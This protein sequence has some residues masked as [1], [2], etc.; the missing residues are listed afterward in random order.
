MNRYCLTIILI[1]LTGNLFAQDPAGLKDNIGVIRDWSVY[2]TSLVR[3]SDPPA[4]RIELTVNAPNDIAGAILEVSNGK[5]RVARTELPNLKKGSNEIAVFLPEPKE[6][7]SAVWRILDGKKSDQILAQKNLTWNKPR[8]WTIYMIGSTHTDIGLHN[9]QYVQR[10]MTVGYLDKVKDLIDANANRPDPSRYRYMIEGTWVW[11]NYEHD[12]SEKTAQDFAENYIKKGMVALGCTCAGNHTQVYGFEELCRSTYYKQMLHDRWG[13]DSDTMIMSDNNGMIWSIVA[14]YRNAGI[15]NIIFSP[16]QWNPLPSTIFKMD[17]SVNGANWNPDAGGG[18]SRIDVRYDSPLPMVFYWLGADDSSKMLVWCVPLYGNGGWRFGFYGKG[19]MDDFGEMVQKV[20]KQLRKLEDRYPFDIWLFTQYQDDQA[21]NLYLADTAKKWNAQW[22]SPEFRT[23]GDISEPFNRL[24]EKYED[25]IT[26]LRGD[27]TSGWSQHPVAAPELLAQK[28]NADVALANAE[29]LAALA[30][31]LDEKY[32]YPAVELR[33]AWD[34]LI[35]NDEHSYG[36][37]GYKGRRVFETWIQHRDWIDKAE[38]TARSV[39]Q[40]ALDVLGKKISVQ[41]DSILLFNPTLIPRSEIMELSVNGKTVQ[42]RTPKIPSFGYKVVSKKDL[43]TLSAVPVEKGSEKTPPIMENRF[44][45]ILFASDGSIQSIFDKDLGRELIDQKS[46]YRC[47]QFVYTKDNH[48]T[49]LSPEK[50][51]F[52]MKSDSL[53]STVIARLNDKNT[54]AE[55]TQAVFLPNGEKRIDLDNQ[56]KH[57]YDLFNTN[58]YYRY[59]YY[60]FPFDVPQGQFYAQLNGAIARPKKDSTG[61]GTDAYLA[62]RDWTAVENGSFGAALIQIDSNLIEFGQIHAD[63][64]DYD[65]P[66]RTSHLYSYLFNDWLQMHTSGGSK[67]EPRFRYTIYSYQGNYQSADLSRL[68]Q[69]TVNPILWKDLHAHSA[70]AKDALPL[71]KSFMKVD[72]PNV[73]F[74]TIKAAEEAGKGFIVRLQETDG[75]PVNKVSVEQNLFGKNSLID[76]CSITEQ[77]V[78]AISDTVF[79][80]GKYEYKTIRFAPEQDQKIG[81]PELKLEKKTDCLVSLSWKPIAGAVQYKVYRGE[82]SEFKPDE[83]HLIG[84]VSGES[85]TDRFLSPDRMYYYRILPEGKNTEIGKC[86]AVLGVKTD[87]D[88]GSAPAPIGSVYTG[89][90]TNP[91]AVHGEEDGQL[92]LIWGQNTESDLSH[93]ELY[94]SEKS[95]FKPNAETFLTKVGPGEYRVGLKEEKG[96]KH[97]T[98]Y[99]YRVR[100]VDQKGHKGKF[101]EEFSGLTREQ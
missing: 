30:R 47:N 13:V 43:Q 44:Y 41:E 100:A 84:S 17:K 37:S 71:E 74:L 96:L 11:G 49:F 82:F 57:V 62:A 87:P 33:N 32:L 101:S 70:N 76:L 1:L 6:G 89:L 63:K 91:K 15:K 12:R 8:H 52:Q 67:I 95:G 50:A 80:F 48:K 86:S 4:Q 14:P 66:Y 79:S 29:K 94:R 65:R 7:F 24:R 10:K 78:K 81:S 64:T 85:F 18:G 26:V 93:Y 97:H 46:S 69:R 73:R 45:K 21:P 75:S 68:A 60:A 53:G 22:S 27:I 5:D 58:R 20:S 2:P 92:Y 36:T 90:I 98:R 55:L 25:Q 88:S 83:Y 3:R 56:F 59:G 28:R 34:M 39:S 61:H 16:N 38:Q 99:Y 35:Y 51:E 77:P 19:K 23:T 9:S 72:V 54:G 31:I 40:N 42:I